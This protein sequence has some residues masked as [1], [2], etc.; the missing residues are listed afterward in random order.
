MSNTFGQSL[1]VS[2]DTI[3]V[4]TF[5]EDSAQ[6]TITNGTT[7]SA[8]NT[9]LYSGAA[10][11]FVRSGT[12][13]TQQAYLKAPNANAWNG[14]FVFRLHSVGQLIYFFVNRNYS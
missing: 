9:A 13:W 6:T 4:G 11:V 2:G 10:Y 8:D 7:A 5:N 3:V 12:I 14:R 1:D